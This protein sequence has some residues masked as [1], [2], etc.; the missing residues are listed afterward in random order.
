[1]AIIFTPGAEAAA[2]IEPVP[3]DGSSIVSP[4]RRFAA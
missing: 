4:S 1:L 3:A 2:T